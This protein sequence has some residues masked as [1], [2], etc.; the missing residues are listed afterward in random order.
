[1]ERYQDLNTEKAGLEMAL[2]EM[3]KQKSELMTLKNNC[4]EE[5]NKLKVNFSQISGF[6]ALRAHFI[7][8]FITH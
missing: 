4:E 1:M 7:S 6:L 3:T 2:E 8:T 5:I